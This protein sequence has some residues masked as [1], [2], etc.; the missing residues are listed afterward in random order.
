MDRLRSCSCFSNGR[1][2]ERWVDKAWSAMSSRL[3]ALP[4]ATVEITEADLQ[5]SLDRLLDDMK[6]EVTSPRAVAVAPL[7]RPPP[8]AAAGIEAPVVVTQKIKSETAVEQPRPTA[9]KPD[10]DWFGIQRQELVALQEVMSELG[11]ASDSSIDDIAKLV[12]NVDAMAKLTAKLKKS[13]PELAKLLMR[14]WEK[15]RREFEEAE[16]KRKEEEERRQKEA[17]EKAQ[18][19]ADEK[20]R[21]RLRKLAR[22]RTRILWGCHGCLRT[23][24]SEYPCTYS[25]YKIRVETY[26][27][28][29]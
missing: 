11:I 6:M 19:E 21:A 15:A 24:Y 25:P 17:E 22:Q 5:V 13:D 18:R 7:F 29:E 2:V 20:E 12:D 4:E 10:G 8:V 1:S 27:L 9:A 28:P 14:C 26:E 16:R 3:H 23:G